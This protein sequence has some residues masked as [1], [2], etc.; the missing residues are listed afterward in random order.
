MSASKPEA[1]GALSNEALVEQFTS[2]SRW[3]H[4][5]P[6]GRAQPSRFELED[7]ETELRR[8]LDAGSNETPAD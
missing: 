7:L 4:Y 5:D 6:V 2:M 1:L 8:R 3:W